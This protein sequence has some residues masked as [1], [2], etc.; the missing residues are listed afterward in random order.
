MEYHNGVPNGGSPH[1]YTLVW[2]E[3]ASKF[4]V[5]KDDEV[6]TFVD[7][8]ITCHKPMKLTPTHLVVLL[9]LKDHTLIYMYML[10]S[11]T[12]DNGYGT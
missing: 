4:S 9:F 3:N 1:S 2:F 7:K 6:T 10:I 12:L 11:L 8:I 5:G